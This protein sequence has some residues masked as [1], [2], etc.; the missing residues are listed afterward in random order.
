[1]PS[2][3][4]RSEYPG[5]GFASSGGTSVPPDTQGAVGPSS[6]IETVNQAVSIFSPPSTGGNVVT[7]QLADFF[8]TQGKLPHASNNDGQSDSFVTFV[9][10]IQRFIVGDLDFD[11]AL[12]NGGAN[13]L[14]LAVSKSANPATLTSADWNFYAVTTTESGVA[15][16]DYPGNVGYNADALV[17]TLNSFSS[18]ADLHTQVNA[19]SLSALASGTPL[20]VGTN[21]F[22]TDITSDFLPRPATMA[23]AVGGEPMWMVAAA[24]NGGQSAG[25]ASTVDVIKMTN[26]L[27]SNPTFTTTT[28]AINPYSLAVSPLQPNGQAITSPG[29]T[30]S[31][32]MKT[33][34]LNGT[35]VA[36]QIISDAAGDLDNSRWYAFDVSSGTPVLSQQ[37]D[38]TG[39][40]GTYITYPGIDINGKGDIGMSYMQSGTAPGQFLSVYVTGRTPSD[41]PGTMET[42]VLAQAGA[43]NYVENGFGQYR[44]GDMSGINVDGSGNFWIA[45]EYANTDATANWGTAIAQFSLGEPIN[46]LLTSATEGVAMTN[47]PVATFVDNSG[48]FSFTATINWGDG[49]VTSGTVIPTTSNNT[50]E[51]LGSHT[52]SEEGNYTISVS[53]NNGTTTVGPVSAT[54][55]VAD[56]PLVGGP[57][58]TITSTVGTFVTNAWVATFTDTDATNV[59]GDPQNNPADY[60]ATIQWFQAGG[61]SATSTGRLVAIGNNSYE[62]FGDNPFSYSGAGSYVVRV[63]IHDK[64]GAS[65]VVNS[66]AVVAGNP[67]IPPLSP[68]FGQDGG[69]PGTLFEIMQNAL[70]NLITAERFLVNAAMFG[71]AAQLAQAWPNFMNA[72]FEYE[73]AVV[74]YDLSLPMGPG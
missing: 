34:E 36:T 66:V 65:V 64:G 48:A 62:V 18:S 22:Q 8:F 32:I 70:T 33:S 11:S 25:T 67:A 27:S 16:Q 37:G 23:G 73:L 41:A 26:V 61:I 28:L 55:H 14:L 57:P 47:V 7:D 17:I 1:V 20:A 21:L 3:A 15:L 31:R 49:T 38:V 52:Y 40:P 45:N 56:A 9:P 44:L 54:I 19:I 68:Q 29:F 71:P 24:N 42:P 60:T 12:N 58:R 5:M 39:G 69:P 43:G 72:F 63:T 46:I 10:Q 50:F 53:E 30:D 59:P 6:Y 74:Q 4:L 2:I 51:I 35:L 13:A